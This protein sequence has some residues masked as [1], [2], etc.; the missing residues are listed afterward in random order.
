[1][2]DGA[3]TRQRD[4]LRQ[5][6]TFGLYAIRRRLSRM[7]LLR[8]PRRSSSGALRLRML[9]LVDF[10]SVTAQGKFSF[11]KAGLS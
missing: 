10:P 11:R 4:G 9:G 3:A 1:M 8:T 5:A 6:S 7:M 2:Y